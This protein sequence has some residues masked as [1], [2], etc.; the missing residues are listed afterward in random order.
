[1]A[2]KNSNNMLSAPLSSEIHKAHTNLVQT[3]NEIPDIKFKEKLYEG[4]GGSVSAS[5]IIAYQ[6]GWGSLLIK[7]YETGLTSDNVS[8]P[9]AGFT[10]WDYVGIAHH[11]YTHYASFERTKLMQLFKNTVDHIIAITEREYKSGNLDKLGVWQWCRLKSGKEW[12][13]SKWI[14]VNTIA[15]YKRARILLR[16]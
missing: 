15:P 10:S 12:P 16:S 9:G 6:I 8:M 14:R 7:W 4:T 11:F 3:V 2:L 5:D 1:M 13:L